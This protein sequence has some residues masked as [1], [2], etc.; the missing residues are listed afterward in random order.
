M[1]T[2]HAPKNKDGEYENEDPIDMQKRI[3]EDIVD[4][5]AER[6]R[7][8]RL[9]CSCYSGVLT[10]SCIA[11]AG[12]SKSCGGGREPRAFTTLSS[13]CI[14]SQSTPDASAP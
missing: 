12:E 14:A 10:R 7:N 13:N 3:E 8:A 9:Y 5:Q 2:Q 11:W 4:I 6:V 1:Y